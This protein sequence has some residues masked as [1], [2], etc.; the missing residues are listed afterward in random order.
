MITLIRAI[1]A[2]IMIGITVIIFDWTTDILFGRGFAD[3][4][5]NINNYV[6]RTSEKYILKLFGCIVLLYFFHKPIGKALLNLFMLLKKPLNPG[7]PFSSLINP[8]GPQK[9]KGKEKHK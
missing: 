8:S 4:G 5:F 9:E 1:F 3:S 7:P 6:L 2:F